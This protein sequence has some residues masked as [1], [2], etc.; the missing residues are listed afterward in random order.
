MVTSASTELSQ[1]R[2]DC[3]AM[4]AAEAGIPKFVGVT[5]VFARWFPVAL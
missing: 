4:G 3:H 5:V 1:E 2:Q